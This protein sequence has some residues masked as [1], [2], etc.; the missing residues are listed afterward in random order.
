MGRIEEIEKRLDATLDDPW[1]WIMVDDGTSVNVLMSGDRGIISDRGFAMPSGSREIMANA[2]VDLR[3]LLGKLKDRDAEIERLRSDFKTANAYGGSRLKEADDWRAKYAA[4]ELRSQKKDKEI[5]WLRE[6]VEAFRELM[7][8]SVGVY[9]LHLN[10]DGA[11][12]SSLLSGGEFE[13]WLKVLD[14]ET[15]RD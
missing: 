1:K 13:C 10:G 9:G 3:Y 15:P 12:W 7:A 6:C 5:V 8:D 11:P 2:P 14:P 4:S